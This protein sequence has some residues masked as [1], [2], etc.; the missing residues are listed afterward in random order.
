MIAVVVSTKSF[1]VDV[2]V[3]Y[4][5]DIGEASQIAERAAREAVAEPALAGLLMGE[6]T[7]LG[8]QSVTTEGLTLRVT[9][10]TRPGEQASVRRVLFEAITVA[11]TAAAIPPPA[12]ASNSP[13]RAS[14]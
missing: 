4:G 7:V 8:V 12:S 9:V 5:A 1:L 14:A 2:P 3:G 6:P 11:F 13:P 10:T